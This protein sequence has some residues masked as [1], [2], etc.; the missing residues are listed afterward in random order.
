M[1]L[2]MRTAGRD[3]FR[4]AAGTLT[5][6]VVSL[7]LVFACHLLLARTLGGSGYGHYAYA[8]AWLNVLLVPATLGADRLVV[9][10]VAVYRAAADWPSWRGLLEWAGRSVLG[11]ALAL[12]LLAIAASWVLGGRAGTPGAFR[13]AMLL[14]P[15]LALVRLAQYALQGMQMPVAGQV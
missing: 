10:Q 6:R 3:H 11:A 4:A 15:A 2:P 1:T 14:L 9:R 7:G 5:L 13:T 12:S 8:L